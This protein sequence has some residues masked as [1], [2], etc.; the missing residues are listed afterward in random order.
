MGIREDY[1]AAQ[2]EAEAILTVQENGVEEGTVDCAVCGDE[3]ENYKYCTMCEWDI[4][5]ALGGDREDPD[6]LQDDWDLD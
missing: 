1:A 2:V 5:E 4:I 6:C 3:T